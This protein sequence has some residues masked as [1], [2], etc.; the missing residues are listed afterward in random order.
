MSNTV[1]LFVIIFGFVVL[2]LL[3]IFLMYIPL[4]RIENALTDIDSKVEEAAAVIKPVIDRFL[5]LLETL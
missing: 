4:N 1:L 5:P 3:N 2:L